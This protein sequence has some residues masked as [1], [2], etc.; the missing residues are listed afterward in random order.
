MP[1]V[2]VFL[3]MVNGFPVPIRTWKGSHQYTDMEFRWGAPID[4]WY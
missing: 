2:K 4:T 1:I 3:F